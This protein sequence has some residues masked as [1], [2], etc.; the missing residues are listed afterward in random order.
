MSLKRTAQAAVTTAASLAA[1]LFS[2]ALA[3][4][5]PAPQEPGVVDNAAADN[6]RARNDQPAQDPN[7]PMCDLVKAAQ[8]LPPPDL[9]GWNI[10]PLV[11]VSVP[12]GFGVGL[13]SPVPAIAFPITLGAPQ[14]P[15]PPDLTQLPAPQL[16]PPPSLPSWQPTWCGPGVPGFTPCI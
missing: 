13:P 15:P 16:P 8:Q 2:D 10:P 7:C 9:S 4:A 6:D 3:T 12:V 14:L 1:L 5:D 11:D